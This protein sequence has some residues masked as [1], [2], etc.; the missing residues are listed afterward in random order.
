MKC[1]EGANRQGIKVDWQV[2]AEGF[3]GRTKARELIP[4]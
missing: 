4:A 1:V 2:V 3:P